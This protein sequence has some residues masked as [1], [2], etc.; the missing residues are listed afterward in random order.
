MKGELMF[1]RDPTSANE[2]GVLKTGIEGGN[3]EF[4]LI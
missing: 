3:E 2:Y 4:D 1:Y